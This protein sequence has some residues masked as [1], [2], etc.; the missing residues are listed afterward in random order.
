MFE[1]I[2]DYV[3]WIFSH[4]W[5]FGAVVLLGLSVAV[6]LLAGLITL[7]LVLKIADRLTGRSRSGSSERRA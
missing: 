1:F 4:G 3:G 7:G 6:V 5:S 2:G